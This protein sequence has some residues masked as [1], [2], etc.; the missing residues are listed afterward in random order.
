MI[1]SSILTCPMDR[2]FRLFGYC[3]VVVITGCLQ[4]WVIQQCAADLSG[5]PMMQV[6]ADVHS[7]CITD[8]P[9][10]VRTELNTSFRFVAEM[11]AQLLYEDAWWFRHYLKK[12]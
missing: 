12:V 10:E 9:F 1:S 6:Y 4:R 8:A 11:P 3:S 2:H 7:R 5:E